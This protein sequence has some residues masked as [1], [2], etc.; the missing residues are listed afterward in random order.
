MHNRDHLCGLILG[1]FPARF[2][3]LPWW[4]FRPLTLERQETRPEVF[5]QTMAQLSAL[6]ASQSVIMG[7]SPRGC[8]CQ[9]LRGCVVHVALQLDGL[10]GDPE[11]LLHVRVQSRIHPAYRPFARDQQVAI[12]LLKSRVV[13]ANTDQSHD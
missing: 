1:A 4:M 12:N 13:E 9:A 2:L 8:T 3:V 10:I 11:F 6:V 7:A 5:L